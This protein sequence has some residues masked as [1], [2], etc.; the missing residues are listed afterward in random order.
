MSSFNTINAVAKDVAKCGRQP[1]LRRSAE[2]LELHVQKHI[3]KI[4]IKIRSTQVT[5]YLWNTNVQYQQLLCPSLQRENRNRPNCYT[6]TEKPVSGPPKPSGT[7]SCLGTSS[8]SRLQT[9]IRHQTDHTLSP[10]RRKEKAEAMFT[11][12]V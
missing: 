11:A 5:R 6:H 10:F 9:A 7:S 3:I 2:G 4:N 8:L 1:L 12:T